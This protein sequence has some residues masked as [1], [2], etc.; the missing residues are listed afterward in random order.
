[1]LKEYLEKAKEYKKRKEIKERRK[2]KAKVG[3]GLAVGSIIGLATG[4]LLA[5]KAGKEVRGNFAKK[6][7]DAVQQAK[8]LMQEQKIRLAGLREKPAEKVS[9]EQGEATEPQP[10]A[11]EEN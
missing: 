6:A 1:M 8:E 3:A 11:K 7:T 9:A 4:I 10:E 5:P 2:S